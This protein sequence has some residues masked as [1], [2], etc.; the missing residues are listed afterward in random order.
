MKLRFLLFFLLFSACQGTSET[1][2]TRHYFDT[3]TWMESL[4]TGLESGKPEVEKTWVY[5]GQRQTRAVKDIDW[6]KELRL[7]LD[8]DLNKSSFVTSYDSL[9]EAYRTVYRLKPGEKLPI[10]ELHILLDSTGRP[11]E[12]YCVRHSENTFFTTGSEI[13]LA[14]ENDRLTAYEIRSV[15]KLLWFRPDS[16]FVSGQIIP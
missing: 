5:D 16:S 6:D 14:A 10:K 8:A 12:M 13:R 1:S 11:S 4:L 2:R 7:F 3:R 15:Q 9:K